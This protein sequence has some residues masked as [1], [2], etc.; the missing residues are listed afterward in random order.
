MHI[1]NLGLLADTDKY[2]HHTDVYGQTDTAT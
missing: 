1:S 2:S